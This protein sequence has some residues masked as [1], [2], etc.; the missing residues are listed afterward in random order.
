MTTMLEEQTTAVTQRWSVDRAAS[1]ID[2]A[3]KT[4]WGLLTVRGR[5]DRFDG[6]YEVGR[7]G[8]EI[9]LTIQADSLETSNALRDT[10]LR[11]EDFFNIVLHPSVRFRSTRVEEA[12]DGMLRVAG[13]LQ[14]AGT[15]VPVELDATV[16]EVGAD[17]E[18]EA[19]TTVDQRQFGMSSGNLGMVRSPA[20]LHVKAR[21]RMLGATGPGN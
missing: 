8:T 21:L 2:F 16:Q 13:T 6:Y 18:I 17:L 5:F 11:S 9:E 1:S 20:T 14:A 19:T 15:T 4:F 12:D 10:H 7:D 3:V